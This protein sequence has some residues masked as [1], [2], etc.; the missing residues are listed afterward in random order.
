[1]PVN[2]DVRVSQTRKELIELHPV[3]LFSSQEAHDDFIERELSQ[4]LLCPPDDAIPRD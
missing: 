2:E 3:Y 4:R 1:M